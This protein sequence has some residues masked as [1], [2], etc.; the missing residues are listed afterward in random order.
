MRSRLIAAAVLLILAAC[1]LG[2]FSWM[3]RKSVAVPY[4]SPT[5]QD[6]PH[7]LAR[8]VLGLSGRRVLSLRTPGLALDAAREGDVLLLPRRSGPLEPLERRRLLDW[9]DA[10]GTLVTTLRRERV[11]EEW[12]DDSLLLGVVLASDAEGEDEPV[13]PEADS[14]LDVQTATDSFPLRHLFPGLGGLGPDTA[15][16]VLPGLGYPLEVHAHAFPRLATDGELTVPAWIDSASRLAVLR[17]GAGRIVVAGGH[18]WMTNRTLGRLDHAQLLVELC[19]LGGKSSRIL[20]VDSIEVPPWYRWLWTHAW[21]L[22]V[23]TGLLLVFWLWHAMVRRGPVL[24]S[25]DPLRRSLREHVEAAGQW[26]W[27]CEDGPERMLRRVREEAM[28]RILLRHPSLSFL[29]PSDRNRELARLLGMEPEAVHQALSEPV[30]R[31]PA[32]FTRTLRL[33]QELEERR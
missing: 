26:W 12:L 5:A 25:P 19:R 15:R 1:V 4:A 2:W 16:I 11:G 29:P 13:S 7:L 3:E 14:G 9:V 18:D 20:L 28:E 17:H 24:P 32:A 22:V 31:E 27:A 8:R 30:G 23:G 33:L 10:D 21:S 6:D